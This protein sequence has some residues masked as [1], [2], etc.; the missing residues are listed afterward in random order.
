MIGQVRR[1]VITGLGIVSSIGI[2]ND[3]VV[4]AL[5]EMKS[6]IKVLPERSDLG[7]RSALSG[8]IEGFEPRFMRFGRKIKKSMPEFVEWAVDAT[9]EA[10]DVA[11]LEMLTLKSP[12]VGLIFGNDSVAKPSY[13]QAAMTKRVKNTA[14][15][16][17]GT[18]FQSMN[19]TV[20]M[21]LNS[22][23]G[24]QGAA[25]TLS[26][27]CASG[28]HA[29][30][31]A[32]DLIA[33]G[34]QKVM[35]CG[36]AQEIT[37]ES[38]C[39]FDALCAFSLREQ[40]P[41]AASRPFDRD[42]DGLVPSGGAAAV[43]LEDRDFALERG[44]KILG[45]VCGYAFS[46]DGGHIA[47]PNGDG[48]ERCMREALN[49]ADVSP[50]QI[51]YLC[52]HGTSTPVGDAVEAEAI[53][54]VFASGSPWVSSLKSMTGHEMWMSGAAQVVYTLLAA[55]QGFIPGNLNFVAPDE[56]TKCL[57]IN[58]ETLFEEMEFVLCNAAGFGGTNSCLVLK[59]AE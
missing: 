14:A 43:I 28:S 9:L 35:I 5:K 11:K 45:E 6:G 20:T 7:F 42:R 40:D 32:A 12:D 49:R 55:G 44:A 51:D 46:S 57:R 4:R 38:V 3:A 13:D 34:R 50:S 48:I 37:W 18:V 29:V 27:A 1:V 16:H 41:T 10:L 25:W 23:L 39:S 22:L 47:V 58:P 59:I 54:R 8:V 56:N 36:G 33:A 26:G 17:S 21:N 53:A 52:A 31:Q 15:L 2:G 30:G 19:S 24:T